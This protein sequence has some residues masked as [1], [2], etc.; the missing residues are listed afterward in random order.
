M[1]LAYLKGGV[2]SELTGFASSS[3]D[4]ETALNEIC[5]K[6]TGH[7]QDKKKTRIILVV[8]SDFLLCKR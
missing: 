2:I 6:D 8:I 1:I 5:E 3:L 4:S 7:D